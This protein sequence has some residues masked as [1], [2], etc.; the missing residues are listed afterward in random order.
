MD[1][2]IRLELPNAYYRLKAI[3]HYTAIYL[4]SYLSQTQKDN[5]DHLYRLTIPS[6]DGKS[7][8]AAPDHSAAEIIEILEEF[9][10]KKITLT[11]SVSPI[12]P[13]SKKVA[14]NSATK[15]KS[16]KSSKSDDPP[17][18]TTP[19][20]EGSSVDAQSKV[21][22]SSSFS[23]HSCFPQEKNDSMPKDEKGETPPEEV[24]IVWCIGVN[25]FQSEGWS[26]REIEKFIKG[27]VAA[28][29]STERS[30]V[31][32]LYPHL[33][34]VSTHLATLVRSNSI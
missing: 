6:D 13:T 21:T 22:N 20:S 26:F 29:L 32:F 4:A 5:L 11:D 10:Q 23:L 31:P 9:F 17:V 1:H 15:K 28:V 2:V 12:P 19:Q 34:Q 30:L 16:K 3:L 33:T 24:D 14:S 25:L 8:K 18:D 7:R 27:L